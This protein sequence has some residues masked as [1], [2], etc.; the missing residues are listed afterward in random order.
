LDDPGLRLRNTQ[1]LS[2]QR[3]NCAT[4]LFECFA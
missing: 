2:S 1:R 4:S 3:Y